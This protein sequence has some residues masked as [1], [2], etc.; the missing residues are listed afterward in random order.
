M[1]A[2]P[3]YWLYSSL[4][5]RCLD[6]FQWIFREC[7]GDLYGLGA[8]DDPCPRAIDLSGLWYVEYYNNGDFHCVSECLGPYPC[9]GRA[10]SYKEKYQTF[11]EWNW[12][13]RRI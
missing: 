5:A 3:D 7:M 11:T 8:I 1:I 13:E 12:H 6:H 9:N 4:S 2:T 10:G